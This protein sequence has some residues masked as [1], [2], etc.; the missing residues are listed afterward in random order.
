MAIFK[1]SQIAVLV[2]IAFFFVICG[3]NAQVKP[4]QKKLVYVFRINDEI[5]KPIWFKT[6]K[7]LQQASDKKADIILIQ[8]NTYGGLLES[9]DSI[10]TA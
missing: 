1:S 3:L 2:V 4:G 7:A 9:A 6:K 8:M 5:G 10:R